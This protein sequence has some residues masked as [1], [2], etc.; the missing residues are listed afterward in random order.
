M[1]TKCY[2]RRS[3]THDAEGL[4][5][6]V[7]DCLG[8]PGAMAMCFTPDQFSDHIKCSTSTGHVA[9]WSKVSTSYKVSP[10]TEL[11]S[12]CRPWK[13]NR[14]DFRRQWCMWVPVG[15]HFSSQKEVDKACR[16]AKKNQGSIFKFRK[17]K[18][19]PDGH[20]YCAENMKLEKCLNRLQTDAII[21]GPW[22]LPFNIH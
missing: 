4:Q 1:D 17:Y 22:A 2:C 7:G 8:T 19:L 11:V 20:A 18:L 14:L 9:A 3:G 6:T 21:A 13:M 15:D 10:V 12:E 16:A 5:S